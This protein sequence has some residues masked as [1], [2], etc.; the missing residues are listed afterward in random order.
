MNLIEKLYMDTHVA[1][2]SDNGVDIDGNECD[3][4]SVLRTLDFVFRLYLKT[5]LPANIT[6]E[7]MVEYL[8]AEGREDEIEYMG[9]VF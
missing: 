7:N 2:A 9:E 3:A 1:L 8:K 4:I 5:N 6:H